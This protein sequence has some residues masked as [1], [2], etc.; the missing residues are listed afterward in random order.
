MHLHVGAAC[1]WERATNTACSLLVV[2]VLLVPLD[3]LECFLHTGV[4][5]VHT[6]EAGNGLVGVHCWRAAGL[7]HILQTSKRGSRQRS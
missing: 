3:I 6:R 5:G 2:T 1:I 4:V 7:N